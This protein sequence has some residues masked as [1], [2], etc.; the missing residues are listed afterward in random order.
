MDR[1]IKCK[2][3]LAE[4]I[5]DRAGCLTQTEVTKKGII[6]SGVFADIS[7][8][9]KISRRSASKLKNEGYEIEDFIIRS[10]TPKT[11]EKSNDSDPVQKVLEYA[12]DNGIQNATYEEVDNFLKF[13]NAKGWVGKDGTPINRTAALFGWFRKKSDERWPLC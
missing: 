8:K 5:I 11:V 12:I 1:Y 13:N 3:E 2:P 10:T 4:Y 9:G 6:S 7:K